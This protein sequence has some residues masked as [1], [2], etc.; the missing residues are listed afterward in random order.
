[1]KNI[2]ALGA[3]NSKNSINQQFANFVA[4]KIE[5]TQS[6][7]VKLSEYD[8]PLYGID[9]EIENGIPEAAKQLNNLI[10][11]SHG[12]VIS[13][14]EHNG[15]YTAAFKSAFDW[16]SRIDKNVWKNKPMLLLATSPGGRGGKT[17]LELAKNSFPRF[18]GNIIAD[19]SLP[20][21]Q[22]NFKENSITNEELNLELNSKIQ[23]FQQHI[24]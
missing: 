5:N 18:A 11:S 8:L 22:D 7:S 3:S 17:V 24:K 2:I 4:S 12:I 21:F 19:F 23:A 10:E 6:V 15:N 20:S 14:A 13:F 9:Y 16:L 1:M